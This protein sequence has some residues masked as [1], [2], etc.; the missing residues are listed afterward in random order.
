[1][2]QAEGHRPERCIPFDAHALDDS[3]YSQVEGRS[4]ERGS[5][6]EDRLGCLVE[7]GGDL[8]LE[9]LGDRMETFG[10]EWD[11]EVIY[12]SEC[13]GRYEE[14][15]AILV[16][17]NTAYRCSCSRKEIA[18]VASPGIE[19]PVYPGTCRNGARMDATQHA[20][21]LKTHNDTI[22]FTDR[23]YGEIQQQ[24]EHEI[25]DFILQRADG[26]FAYQ[27][28]IVADDAD[29]AINRI[30]RGSDLLLSTPRQILLQQMLG[31]N[32]PGYAHVPLVKDSEGRKLSKS[33]DAW[34]VDTSHPVTTLCMALNFL[35]QETIEADTIDSFWRQATDNW[36]IEQVPR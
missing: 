18:A 26:I 13:V 5:P 33:D 22:K 4:A 1:M 30:V 9:D 16:K 32:T 27:L 8:V 23:V 35:G 12:Q 24:V 34:P 19:G 20:W 2:A 3:R 14:L 21:R 7:R 6:N 29:Q 11:S 28:A 25:G 36:T 10:M 31:F 15:L 17:K